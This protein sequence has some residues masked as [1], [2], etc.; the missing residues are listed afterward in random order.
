M[1]ARGACL[2]KAHLLHVS[3]DLVDLF[4]SAGVLQRGYKGDGLS[5]STRSQVPQLYELELTDGRL[6]RVYAKLQ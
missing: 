4:L 5:V 1:E 2:G 3:D 6:G